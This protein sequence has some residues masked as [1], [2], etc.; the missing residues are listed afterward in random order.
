[1]GRRA[2][3]SGHAIDIC[4]ACLDQVGLAEMKV[5]V[6]RTGGLM[7]LDDQFTSGVF[8]G[9][10]PKIFTREIGTLRLWFAVWGG[11]TIG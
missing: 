8:L 11:H 1:V 7:V 5:A 10:F 2:Q 4:A 6:E 9:S 3:G